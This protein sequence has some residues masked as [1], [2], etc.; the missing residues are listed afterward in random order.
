[1]KRERAAIG[2]FMVAAAA[3]CLKLADFRLFSSPATIKPIVFERDTGA[4][5]WLEPGASAGGALSDGAAVGGWR[6]LLMGTKLSLN[7]ATANDFDALPGIGESLAAKIVDARNAV[8]GFAAPEDLL[9]VKGFGRKRF[10]TLRNW[11]AND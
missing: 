10:E 7:S 3:F 5:R 9:R 6:G 11:I 2:L 4:A 8:G 1:M